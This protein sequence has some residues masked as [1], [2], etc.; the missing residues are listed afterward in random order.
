MARFGVQVKSKKEREYLQRFIA[1][2]KGEATPGMSELLADGQTVVLF[3]G[4]MKELSGG[5]FLFELEPRFPKFYW[6]GILM[7]VFGALIG[8]SSWWFWI[9]TALI[10]SAA[11]LWNS[12]TY[13]ALLCAGYYRNT[14]SWPKFRYVWNIKLLEQVR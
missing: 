2:L 9:P 12:F 4:S 11:L 7:G 8:I 13:Y 5:V 3:G 14:K 10:A 6:F 1:R